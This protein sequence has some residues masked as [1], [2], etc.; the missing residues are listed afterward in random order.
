MKVTIQ[1]AATTPPQKNFCIW[2]V[3]FFFVSFFL[4]MS[5]SLLRSWYA[6]YLAIKLALDEVNIVLWK[7]LA[8]NQYVVV[9]LNF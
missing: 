2:K 6:S 5:P 3:L 4:F 1:N 8:K 9:P 7:C